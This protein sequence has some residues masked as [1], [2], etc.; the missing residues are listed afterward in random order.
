MKRFN[1]ALL[2]LI[3]CLSLGTGGLTL[4]AQENDPV[5][6]VNGVAITRTEL[7]EFMAEEFG[8]YALQELIQREL[9]NQ[10]AIALGVEITEEEF[11]EVYQLI[12]AQVGGPQ[13]LQMF[14]LQNNA[15]EEQFIEQVRMNMLLNALA[16]AEVEVTDEAL[17]AWFESNRDYYDTPETVAVSHILVDTEEDAQ[18]IMRLL[19]E[20]ADFATLAQE[21]SLD[22]GTSSEGGYLGEI[23]RGLTVEEFEKTAF[24]LAIGEL[25]LANSS[26]GWHIILVHAK[27]E[28]ESANYE[29]I[30]HLVALDYRANKA[31]DTQ[32]FLYKLQMDA[33]LE[34]L[35]P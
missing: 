4:R 10:K 1:V 26:Y 17:L 6:V 34:I 7:Y 23:R 18:E 31:L 29:E 30:A 14:L 2:L 25:G 3:L 11:A 24:G 15:T 12:M 27:T 35:W 8:R 21:K 19:A 33:N 28:G 22:P 5:A 13:A 16:E 9:I 20:G 32:S